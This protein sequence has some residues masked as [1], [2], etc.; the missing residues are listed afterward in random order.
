MKRGFIIKTILIIIALILIM[1]FLSF[2]I[3]SIVESP[4]SQ[5][6]IA[7][8]VGLGTLV[9]DKFLSKPVLY[10]WQN[11]FIDLLWESFVSNMERIKQGEP[12]DLQLMAPYVPILDT[13]SEEPDMV[14]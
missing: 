11:I 8:V 10:F 13:Y 2:D 5:K 1:S 4:Q 7:Y 9:W 12:T 6:N 14:Q 3:E